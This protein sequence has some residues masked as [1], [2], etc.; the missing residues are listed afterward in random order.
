MKRLNVTSMFLTLLTLMTVIFSLGM[1]SCKADNVLSQ[2]KAEKGLKDAKQ[3]MVIKEKKRD[4]LVLANQTS[5]EQFKKDKVK[6]V[7]EI[8]SSKGISY[9]SDYNM[10]YIKVKP[11]R[12]YVEAVNV[13]PRKELS[14]ACIWE[15]PFKNSCNV[16][17]NSVQIYN[18]L[19]GVAKAIK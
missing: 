12:T 15:T 7:N 6:V 5:A 18:T 2:L 17:A 16:A 8:L 4:Y 11:W 10:Y 13:D 14:I 1:T 19:R 9:S 3:W